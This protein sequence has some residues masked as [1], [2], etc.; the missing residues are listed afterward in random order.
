MSSPRTQCSALAEVR[1]LIATAVI[2]DFCPSYVPIHA[3]H[4]SKL[5]FFTCRYDAHEREVGEIALKMGF[6]QVS[7]SS[8][9]MPM[10]RIVPRGYTG[11][12]VLMWLKYRYLTAK[13]IQ[14][15]QHVI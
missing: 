10:V 13:K 15:Y 8:T 4:Y 9:I 3:Y 5:S 1:N 7:L 14:P 6:D 11:K 12:G 2:W